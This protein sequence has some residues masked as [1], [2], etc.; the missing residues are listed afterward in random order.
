[1]W[2]RTF[3]Q[4]DVSSPE[5]DSSNQENAWSVGSRWR[6][7]LFGVEGL[8]VD[9]GE[10]FNP[11]VVLFDGGEFVEY[12]V[13]CD[14]RRGPENLEL[15][16]FGLNRSLTTFSTKII[17]WKL[18][19]WRSQVS[20]SLNQEDGSISKLIILLNILKNK[21]KFEELLSRLV[22]TVFLPSAP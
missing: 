3:G 14:T 9:V 8:Y 10:D 1:M 22:N 7:D 21:K 19:I 6:N 2:A 16:V 13:K 4:E 17:N 5:I 11:E 20:L 12:K 18:G 15:S